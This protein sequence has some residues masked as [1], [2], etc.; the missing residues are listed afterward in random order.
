M[1]VSDVFILK[2]LAVS[3]I[4]HSLTLA[5]EKAAAKVIVEDA[6]VEP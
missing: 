5:A 3:A 1:A 4:R 6:S 2:S